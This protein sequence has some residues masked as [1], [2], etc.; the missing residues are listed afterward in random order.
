[1]AVSKRRGK[2]TLD[3]IDQHKQR[4]WETTNLNKRDAERLLA[5]RLQEI[6]RG[7]FEAKSD[8][9]TFDEAVEH[10]RAAHLATNIRSTTRKDY[11]SCLRCHILPYFGG[12]KLRAITSA[13]VERYRGR[14]LEDGAGRRTVN[15]S[16]TQLGSVFR[17][18]VKHGWMEANPASFR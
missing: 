13:M 5:K 4:R 2:W 16:L 17:H 11:E 18:A 8:E 9:K 7:T 10:Y 14:L 1:M 15:K 6:G 12:I 3:Y